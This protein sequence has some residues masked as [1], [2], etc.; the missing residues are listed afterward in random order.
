MRFKEILKKEPNLI[1][2]HLGNGAS[3]CSIRNGK[4]FDTTM[5]LTPLAGLMMGTR[6][7]DVDPSI[8]EYMTRV[9]KKDV[10][11]VTNEMNKNSGLLGTCGKADMRD[12]IAGVEANDEQA[13]FTF[14]LYCQKIA[15]FII[16]MINQFDRSEKVDGI[17]FTAGIGENSA[18]VRKTVIEKLNLL[19]I[20][21][22]ETKNG[23]KYDDFE[24]ISD[25]KS[26]I[27]IYKMKTNEEKMIC[28]SCLEF[29]NN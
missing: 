10:D 25:G 6:S 19:D 22:D 8:I 23:S 29:L 16:K 26:Q 3:I 14:D 13:K 5:G 7:G 12:V 17:V 11:F 24:L 21:L 18:I 20:K 4:S 28:N 2:C 1:V 9:L 15:D 27:G